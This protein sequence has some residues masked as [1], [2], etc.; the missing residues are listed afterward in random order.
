[1]C[2]CASATRTR[3]CKL[4]L[5][6]PEFP[7]N[8]YIEP[9]LRRQ[10]CQL[11]VQPRA[12]SPEHSAP[13]TQSRT[14]SPSQAT[15]SVE[16]Q[17]EGENR[18]R[19]AC[20]SVPCTHDSM[21]KRAR[22]GCW[23]TCCSLRGRTRRGRS[24]RAL[25]GRSCTRRRLY[26]SIRSGLLERLQGPSE[27]VWEET[28]QSRKQKRRTAGELTLLRRGPSELDRSKSRSCGLGRSSTFAPSSSAV[29]HRYRC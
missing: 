29:S 23:S 4:N 13:S 17:S 24:G 7:R 8:L 10:D 20:E 6:K 18:D 15:R 28:H 22:R 1:M 3:A 12:L 14:Q 2:A 19:P 9:A 21:A 25:R 27:S 26:R 11:C 16:L 5:L